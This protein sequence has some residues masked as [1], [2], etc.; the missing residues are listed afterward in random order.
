[1]VRHLLFA[2]F[3]VMLG[4]SAASAQNDT[5]TQEDLKPG[6]KKSKFNY[7]VTESG[8]LLSKG[9]TL[10]LGSIKSDSYNYVFAYVTSSSGGIM[11]EDADKKAA[12]TVVVIQSMNRAANKNKKSF[13]IML[14]LVDPATRSMYIAQYEKALEERE[15]VEVE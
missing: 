7:Y 13:H 2:L 1:M 8:Q 6:V 11:V 3:T 12:G 9:D 5:L 4:I 10:K 15:L 14:T